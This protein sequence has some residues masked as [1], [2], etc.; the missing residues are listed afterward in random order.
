[1]T[2]GDFLCETRKPADPIHRQT[3]YLALFSARSVFRLQ[4][5]DGSGAG[6]LGL[7]VETRP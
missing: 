4:E 5:E 6:G 1:M 7:N 2:N 3:R